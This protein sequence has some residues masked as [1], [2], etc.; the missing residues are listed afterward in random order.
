[1]P[2]DPADLRRRS[3]ALAPPPRET[4][5]PQV[6]PEARGGGGGPEICYV[7]LRSC[8]VE[9][10][11]MMVQRLKYSNAT[12]P[13]TG[14]IEGTGQEFRAYPPPGFDY[15][16]FEH[17][18]YAVDDEE[19]HPLGLRVVALRAIK[20]GGLWIVEPSFKIKPGVNFV[21]QAAEISAGS[22]G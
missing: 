2:I 19:T 6:R 12:A 13:V 21:D 3:K 22:G 8:N 14:E 20:I 1:M 11:E 7:V 18:A 4:I 10:G 9:T 16:Q 17:F 5:R 15:D